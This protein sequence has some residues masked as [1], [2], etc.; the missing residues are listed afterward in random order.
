MSYLH[1][2]ADIRNSGEKLLLRLVCE[3]IDSAC[4]GRETDAYLVYLSSVGNVW[5]GVTLF[6]NLLQGNRSGGVEL[7]LEDIYVVWTLQHT[8]DAPLARLFL[9]VGVVFAKKLHDEVESVLERASP[10][11][12][13]VQVRIL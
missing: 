13:K 11:R 9:N 6:F 3:V 8:V 7:K 2:N 4:L 1:C 10:R 12:E 5:H